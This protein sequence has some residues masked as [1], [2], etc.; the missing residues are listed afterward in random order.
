MS[1]TAFDSSDDVAIIPSADGSGNI[2][3]S[4]KSDENNRISRLPITIPDIALFHDILR[5]NFRRFHM[6]LLLAETFFT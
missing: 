2:F 5:D 6:L 1:I 4:Y 3:V